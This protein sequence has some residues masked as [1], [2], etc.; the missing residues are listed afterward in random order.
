SLGYWVGGDLGMA[1]AALDEVDARC[2][3][4]NPGGRSDG[5]IELGRALIGVSEARWST[6]LARTE[7]LLEELASDDPHGIAP[8]AYAVNAL[9]CAA[10]GESESA[11]VAMHRARRGERGISRALTGVRRRLLIQARQWMRISQVDRKAFE[12]ARWARAQGLALV[13]LQALHI[14]AM[15]SKRNAGSVLEPVRQLAGIVDPSVAAVVLKH[16]EA[17]AEG[18]AP[19]DVSEPE[20]RM[21]ADLGVWVPLPV[22]S[23]LSGRE[24]EVALL[25]ALGYASKAIADRLHLSKRTVDAHL[26]KVYTKLDLADREALRRWFSADRSADRSVHE[27]GASER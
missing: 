5:F 17:M 27:G 8:M 15:E 3:A 10:L 16:V 9:A 4:E 25:A 7:L 22:T 2:R 21:L 13:E 14:V 6:A 12:L 19:W 26:A 24:R 11:V 20:V 18:T 1:A 23:G